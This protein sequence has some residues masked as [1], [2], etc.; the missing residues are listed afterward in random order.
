[1]SKKITGDLDKLIKR[2]A[3][4]KTAG[5]KQAASI[6]AQLDATDDKT[7]PVTTGEQAAKNKSDSAEIAPSAVDG[8]AKTNTV[9]T[10]VENSTEGATAVAAADGASGAVG[11]TG[12]VA[13]ADS[14][15]VALRGAVGAGDRAAG[16]ARP[17]RPRRNAAGAG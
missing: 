10:S 2:A 11:A 3:E 16:A 1:M 5:L 6:S 14:P 8:G 15:R 9:G 7:K 12:R 13:A 4:V 17:A